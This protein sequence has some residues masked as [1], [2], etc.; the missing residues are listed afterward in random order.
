MSVMLKLKTE[1]VF[2]IN[3]M[4]RPDPVNQLSHIESLAMPLM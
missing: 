1:S 2:V 3:Y 4:K